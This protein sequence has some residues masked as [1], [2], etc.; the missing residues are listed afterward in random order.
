MNRALLLATA[1]PVLAL[2]LASAVSLPRKL[3][4]NASESASIGFYWIDQQPI[5]RGDYVYVRVPERVRDIVIERGYL[6]PDVPLLKRVVGSNGD[7]ICRVGPEVSV[8]GTV[9][10]TAKR[11]DGLGREMPVWQGCHML[12]ERRVF[13]L[14]D[15][16]QSFDGRYFGPL[17]R[18]LIIGRATR[19]RLPWRKDKPG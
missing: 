11:H 1:I 19:L 12:H 4:Y 17:D 18:R 7:R 8:N 16:P 14:Q 15:H 13:L 6:Q 3:I 5:S 9:V 10:V 2:G